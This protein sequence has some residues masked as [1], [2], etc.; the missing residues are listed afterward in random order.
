MDYPQ[1]FATYSKLRISRN[2]R[3]NTTPVYS[4]EPFKYPIAF[5]V[6]LDLISKLPN[7]EDGFF[8]DLIQAEK[9]IRKMKSEYE[10]TSLEEIQKQISRLQNRL[11]NLYTDKVDGR[12]T[13]EFWKEKHNLWHDEKDKLIDKLKAISNNSRMFDEGSN[14]LENFC[15]YAQEEFSNANGKKKRAIL[16][17]LGSNFI[18]KNKKVSIELT[19]VFDYL[20]NNP[21]VKYGGG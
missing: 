2:A 3:M 16:K 18:Y 19:S 21:S 8:Q 1:I 17:M 11:D 5:E 10:E 9:E 7:P 20:I 12:I 6:F 14:L 13:Y 15:K 4:K